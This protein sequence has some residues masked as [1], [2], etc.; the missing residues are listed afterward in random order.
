[1]K[2]FTERCNFFE[3]NTIVAYQNKSPSKHNRKR[4]KIW[5]NLPGVRIRHVFITYT[6]T[7]LHIKMFSMCSIINPII[8]LEK[9]CK[10]KS[11][12]WKDFRLKQGL[13]CSKT[14]LP[15]QW[16]ETQW[17]FEFLSIKKRIISVNKT[18]DS[19]PDL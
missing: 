10:P 14:I 7:L 17:L 19:H 15:F 4:R 5:F 12:V 16:N 1:M 11:N 18:S 9:T 8:R 2:P 6:F 3:K 13:F